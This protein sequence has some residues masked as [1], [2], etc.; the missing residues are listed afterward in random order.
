MTSSPKKRRRWWLWGLATVLLL[1]GL[2]GLL[3][4]LASTVL[5]GP[6]L[7]VVQGQLGAVVEADEVTLSWSGEQLLQGV[8]IAPEG[9]S[10]DLLRVDRVRLGS[11]LFALAFSPERPIELEVDGVMLRVHRADDGTFNFADLLKKK[12]DQTPA[13]RQAPKE[14]PTKP[15]SKKR[16][17]GETVALAGLPRDLHIT[18]RNV[19][20]AYRDDV[21]DAFSALRGVALELHAA[22]GA[23]EF[24]L[25]A[26]VAS[27]AAD[28][29][30]QDGSLAISGAIH[31][32]G[33]KIPWK[34]LEAHVKITVKGLALAPYRGLLEE[35]AN[36]SPPAQPLEGS[37]QVVMKDG[38]LA[39]DSRL[40]SDVALL[41]TLKITVP[42]SGQA[43]ARFEVSLSSLDLAGGFEIV[44][45]HLG[46]PNDTTIAGILDL[47]LNGQ[48]QWTLE[49]LLAGGNPAQ[50]PFSLD[51]RTLLSDFALELPPAPAG[52]A[53]MAGDDAKAEVPQVSPKPLHIEEKEVTL[54][55]LLQN[56]LPEQKTNTQ[57][58]PATPSLV[59]QTKAH[60]S[61]VEA[62]FE[63][64]VKG[65]AAV[66]TG[67]L[68]VALPRL[69]EQ[70]SLELPDDLTIAEGTKLELAELRASSRFDGDNPTATALV[71]AQS[72]AHLTL[73]GNIGFQGYDLSALD[74]DLEYKSQTAKL[75]AVKAKLSDGN[76]LAEELVIELNKKPPEYHGKVIVEDVRATYEMTKL[77]A[78]AVPFLSLDD[79]RAD[80][81]GRL[82]AELELSGRGFETAD[83]K[84]ALKGKGKLRIRDGK[85]GA[86]KFF[87]KVVSLLGGK[88]EDLHFSEL[89]SDFDIGGARVLAHKVFLLPRADSKL[90]NLGLNGVTGFDGALDFSVD[91]AALQETIGD[92]R[93]RRI[94][95]S[96]RK[97]F[98]GDSFPLRLRGTLDAP[99]L[100]LVTPLT[101]TPG[102]SAGKP[103]GKT[104][105]K[106]PTTGLEGI[107]KRGLDELLGGKKKKKKRK[108]K[109]AEKDT[110]KDG[111]AAEATKKPPA[112]DPKPISVEDIFD[113]FKKKKK[114]RKPKDDG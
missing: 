61:A 16:D 56:V 68:R 10:H 96:T 102:V 108:E 58:T 47:E 66:A 25:D 95:Q 76:V 99:K 114:R 21:L 43:P 26:H 19:D 105:P 7:G 84:S 70:L 85:L 40:D 94:L 97:L 82:N 101:K 14:R 60:S 12:P 11:S 78:Y 111:E 1:G 55:I 59:F 77:L 79:E 100:D 28:S 72:S 6:L 73:S 89:G 5:R 53:E 33:K 69:I 37:L 50:V 91:L 75:K 109:D 35:F 80:F 24:T 34:E 8:R 39:V 90:R 63:G 13:E 48:G 18:V 44:R 32:L 54:T 57:E 42:A 20:L 74:A 45:R 9:A 62:A 71:T 17:G 92:K 81:S 29:A 104:S 113:L 15:P 98:G 22:G 107:L 86:S 110:Q 64:T 23:A 112:V 106:L 103:S 88:Q 3:P 38:V 67:G 27:S 87:L 31:S 41:E 2:V 65:G 4:L 46:L 52:S 83:L 49:D 51:L 30:G 93:I 36:L